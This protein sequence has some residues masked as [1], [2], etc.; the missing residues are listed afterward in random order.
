[1]SGGFSGDET[2]SARL[3]LALALLV[4][5]GLS[6][7]ALVMVVWEGEPGE[8]RRPGQPTVPVQEP[9]PERAATTPAEVEPLVIRHRATLTPRGVFFGDT[10]DARIDV[11][12]DRN[13][14]D[15]GSVRVAAQFS[16]WET[17]GQPERLRRD[18]GSSTHLQ[19]TYRLRCLS[20]PCVPT[21]QASPL[22]FDPARVTYAVAGESGETARKSLRVNWPVL[23]VYSRFAAAAF[24]G[25]EDSSTP[26]RADALTLPAVTYR[27]P[28][29]LLIGL[30]VLGGGLC[31]TGGVAL[32]Y[33]AR[34]RRAPAPPP[35]P[36]A[37]PPPVLSPLEQALVL[38]EDAV[39]ADGAEDRRRA[40]ELV[41]E[42]LG[43][44]GDPDLA[45][46]AR[47][48]AWSEQEPVVEET[49]GLAQR[50]RS[51]LEL[52]QSDDQKDGDRVV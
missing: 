36:E 17:V 28:P 24:E 2:V 51:K 38:L 20:S 43:E 1:M 35:E 10:V 7:L 49:T 19:T 18:A 26:W 44:H 22:D 37:P 23:T 14:V 8:D 6:A 15:P 45:R 9:T 31:A 52:E 21:G 3:P 4:V 41:A 13:R 25:Q 40:L 12:L 30:L 47:V 11:F 32:L 34:P 29:A 46:S 42:V 48:L 16:P 33:L 50:V 39:R 5:A 27:V